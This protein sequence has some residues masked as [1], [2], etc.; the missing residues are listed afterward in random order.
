[1]IICNSI[2]DLLATVK[3]R[4]W[5]QWQQ[6]QS[7]NEFVIDTR[8]LQQR[9]HTYDHS[10]NQVKG[11]EDLKFSCVPARKEGRDKDISMLWALN[12]AQAVLKSSMPTESSP[13]LCLKDT[14]EDHSGI[15]G[16]KKR[17]EKRRG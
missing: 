13:I 7:W 5:P 8:I 14:K 4:E 1:M 16:K 2:G 10:D 12:Y 3:K 15:Y 6:W 9:N 17:V 11:G